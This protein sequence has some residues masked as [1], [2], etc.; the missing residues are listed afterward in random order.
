MKAITT[1]MLICLPFLLSA[2]VSVQKARP[3]AGE[4]IA[5]IIKNTAAA[6]IP[7]TVD[8]IKEGDPAT[9]VTGIICCMFATMD[10]LKEAV[11][12][13]CNLIVT[14]EPIYFNHLD[15][16]KQFQNDPVFLEKRQY[17]LD[18]KLVIWRFHDYIHSMQPDGILSGMVEKLD[19]K[20]FAI[21][22]HLEQF[23]FPE[24][25]LNELLAGLKKT[26]PGNCFYVIGNPEMKV[27]KVCFSPGA[28]G[29][30]AHIKFLEDKDTDVVILGEVEQWET[31]E[32]A[33]EANLQGR[34]KAIIAL[35]HIP[36]EESGMKFC[37]DWM[38]TF[39]KDVPIEFIKCGSSYWSY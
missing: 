31:Y 8:I 17:I 18:H 29:S 10:V 9:P 34:N 1:L 27:K 37:A 21:D 24:M 36:S 39:I 15:D 14:H 6:T 28:S 30:A 35:G 12:K 4:I 23:L 3:T 5:S 13:N 11:S 33:R 38:K 22:S 7:N 19:W 26:F 32:Y 2:Q 20:P 25:T 16:T